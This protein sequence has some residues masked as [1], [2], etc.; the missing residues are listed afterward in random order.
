MYQVWT[1]ID[2]KTQTELLQ[3]RYLDD[4]YTWSQSEEFFIGGINISIPICMNYV[5][6]VTPIIQILRDNKASM[7][8]LSTTSTSNTKIIAERTKPMMKSLSEA[9]GCRIDFVACPPSAV[10]I[11]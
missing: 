4:I 5:P 8:I 9:K 10:S 2:I 6:K 7:C 3:A 11:S 1:E